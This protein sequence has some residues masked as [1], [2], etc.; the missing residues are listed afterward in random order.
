[1]NPREWKELAADYDANV[2]SVY[3]HDHEGKISSLIHR[4]GQKKKTAI[5]LGCG[6]GKFLPL[7][8]SNF[9][10]VCAC[11]YSAEMIQ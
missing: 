1:M 5:A 3:E 11:D 6:V 9:G 8:S 4:L 2:L 7:L 10:N